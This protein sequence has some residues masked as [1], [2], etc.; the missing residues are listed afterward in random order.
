MHTT[1]L[2]VIATERE[3]GDM[4]PFVRFGFSDRRTDEADNKEFGGRK[5]GRERGVATDNERTAAG[6]PL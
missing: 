5:E 6:Q 4:K 2:P 1:P 3:S